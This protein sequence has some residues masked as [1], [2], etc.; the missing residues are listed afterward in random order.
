MAHCVTSAALLGLACNISNHDTI[1]CSEPFLVPGYCTKTHHGCEPNQPCE[2]SACEGDQPCEP[3]VYA[4]CNITSGGYYK[5]DKSLFIDETSICATQMPNV[6]LTEELTVITTNINLVSTAPDSNVTSYGGSVSGPVE[7]LWAH[8]GTDV[9]QSTVSGP[10][11]SGFNVTTFPSSCGYLACVPVNSTNGT[12]TCNFEDPFNLPG[13]CIGDY[14]GCIEINDGTHFCV[15]VDCDWVNQSNTFAPGLFHFP[16]EYCRPFTVCYHTSAPT[17]F[18]LKNDCLCYQG[19]VLSPVDNV[20]CVLNTTGTGICEENKYR[21]TNSYECVDITQCQ[22]ETLVEAGPYSDAICAEPDICVGV[23]D[24][25]GICVSTRKNCLSIEYISGSKTDGSPVC[26]TISPPCGKHQ[27]E[28]V[29]PTPTADRVCKTLGSENM[30]V[31]TL[32]MM[33]P[34]LVYLCVQI[35]FKVKHGKPAGLRH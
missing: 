23:V 5:F 32:V 22:T 7:S 29:P 21:D 6:T 14:T 25:T 17:I 19:Y 31:V 34:T 11:F 13:T 10:F 33:I 27:I 28:T 3:S 20:T 24:E 16:S 4:N 26:E 35:F 1:V 15:D 2:P 30:I 18:P 12:S 8:D 9:S